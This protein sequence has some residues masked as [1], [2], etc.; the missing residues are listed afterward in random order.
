MDS[1]G[2]RP[3]PAFLS[4][5]KKSAGPSRPASCE[6]ARPEPKARGSPKKESKKISKKKIDVKKLDVFAPTACR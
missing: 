4:V 2:R 6:T 1:S 5:A 3:D